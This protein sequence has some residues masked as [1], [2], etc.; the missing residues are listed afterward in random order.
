MKN[1][2]F[3][4]VERITGRKE[5]IARLERIEDLLLVQMAATGEA[6]VAALTAGCGPHHPLRPLQPLASSGV[7]SWR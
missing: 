2:F 7:R 5:I 4:L 1:W 3:S 6:Q